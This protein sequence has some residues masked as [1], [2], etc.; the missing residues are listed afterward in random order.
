M[1]AQG[2]CQIEII[3]QEHGTVAGARSVCARLL[4]PELER[5][6]SRQNINVSEINCMKWPV[7]GLSRWASC[8]LLMLKSDLFDLLS[9]NP[10]LRP[11]L[12]TNAFYDPG[13]PTPG[14]DKSEKASNL[15]F[16]IWFVVGSTDQSASTR[17]PRMHLAKIT[18]LMC[19]EFGLPDAG[20]AMYL[21]EFR[22]DRWKARGSRL[23]FRPGE[24][25]RSDNET[26]F[27]TSYRNRQFGLQAVS[28]SAQYAKGMSPEEF[29]ASV[30]QSSGPSPWNLTS[31]SGAEKPT[32]NLVRP[33]DLVSSSTFSQEWEGINKLQG[34]PV[35]D[36]FHRPYLTVIDELA[37][38]C[39]SVFTYLPDPSGLIFTDGRYQ[40][41]VI[42]MRGWL[43][44]YTDYS[45]I[46]QDVICG[47]A[48]FTSINT[49]TRFC[50]SDIVNWGISEA[51]NVAVSYPIIEAPDGRPP[52]VLFNRN[53][54]ACATGGNESSATFVAADVSA[55]YEGE[56]KSL[57]LLPSPFSKG[58]S[59]SAYYY[60]FSSP[61]LFSGEGGTAWFTTDIPSIIPADPERGIS[62][63]ANSDLFSSNG[64][65]QFRLTVYP[66]A[67]VW[68]RGWRMPTVDPTTGTARNFAWVE[69]RLQ[70][71]S[72]GFGFPTSRW[73]SDPD[74]PMV[75]WQED[76]GQTS[77][78]G[79]GMVQTYVGLD[80]RTR[81]CVRPQFPIPC[82]LSIIDN[83]QIGDNC[84]KYRAKIVRKERDIDGKV[85]AGG[86][87]SGI[88]TMDDFDEE[89]VVICYNLNEL[90]NGSGFAGPGYKLPLSQAGFSVLPIG[91]D[92]DGTKSPVL[93]LAHLIRAQDPY[94]PSGTPTYGSMNR[95]VGYFSMHNAIDGACVSPITLVE[96]IDGGVF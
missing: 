39:G 41:Q 32:Y 83:E 20:E 21:V 36:I 4:T 33:Q 2:G 13:E 48:N 45:A 84:W 26:G 6:I 81:V 56:I 79:I 66:N 62:Q 63:A 54:D 91:Q 38:K 30:L 12:S 90:G 51:T 37:H 15:G 92:R 77:V 29:F 34:P 50:N 68:L 67:D 78:E 9:N 88:E 31:F 7:R 72:K 64:I 11:P 16:T 44:A 96:D 89:E 35:D 28:A 59:A 80:G 71:D 74:D 94:L 43:G 87:F 75:K 53:A 61:H 1:T 8:K 93:V 18:P 82:V 65:D 55:Q 5:L 58:I 23:R 70:T 42:D 25:R 22:C 3:R 49:I 46:F 86:F 14:Q 40:L 10:S 60:Q 19:S 85:T 24:D 17:F 73:Y 52:A 95:T 57:G 76:V 47:A 27:A 69:L